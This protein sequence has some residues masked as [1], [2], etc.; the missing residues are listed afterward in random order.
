MAQRGGLSGLEIDDV[1]LFL[2]AEAELFRDTARRAHR[3]R[4]PGSLP[5]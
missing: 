3:G 2:D 4:R 5:G 1:K